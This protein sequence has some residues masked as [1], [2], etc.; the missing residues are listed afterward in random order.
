MLYLFHVQIKII[1]LL[2][3]AE[4]GIRF[5]VQI[6]ADVG[7]NENVGISFASSYITG[8]PQSAQKNRMLCLAPSKKCFIV[9]KALND[10]KKKSFLWLKNLTA[11]ITTVVK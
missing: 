11:Q 3:R 8:Q 7:R 5:V 2:D 1:H 10:H 4:S 9:P 6:E